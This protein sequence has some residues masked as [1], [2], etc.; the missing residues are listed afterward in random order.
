MAGKSA[1]KKISVEGAVLVRAA[2]KIVYM[3]LTTNHAENIYE[4]I[5]HPHRRHP[6]EY[7]FVGALCSVCRNFLRGPPVYCAQG[8][9]TLCPTCRGGACGTCATLNG[10]YL[11]R[12]HSRGCAVVASK[13]EMGKH[14]TDCEYNDYACVLDGCT[15][16]SPLQE[17]K[18]HALECHGDAIVQSNQLED[19]VGKARLFVG[20]LFNLYLTIHENLIG[21]TLQ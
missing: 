2:P 6:P 11:C 19:S 4:S 5:H 15:F 10:E 3:T 20:V 16:R 8:Q 7:G 17:V 14:V 21:V 9:H 13:G 1:G 12:N 18:R